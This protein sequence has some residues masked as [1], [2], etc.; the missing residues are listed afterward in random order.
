MG[1][2][3]TEVSNTSDHDFERTAAD[4]PQTPGKSDDSEPPLG[5]HH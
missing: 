4:P 2:G 1:K 3:E 5:R